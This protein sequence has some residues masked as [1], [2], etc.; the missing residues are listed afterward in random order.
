MKRSDTEI[1][2][3]ESID[4]CNLSFETRSK[5]PRLST[6]F[7]KCLKCQ[8]NL[9]EKLSKALHSSILKF[10]DAGKIRKDDVYERIKLE[11]NIILD[12]EQ[13][14]YWHTSCYKEYTNKTNLD[15]ILQKRGHAKDD[16][17]QTDVSFESISDQQKPAKIMRSSVAPL[18]WDLCIFCQNITKLK[19]KSLCQVET[20]KHGE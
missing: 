10:Y 1:D 18:N 2:D 6:D 13:C 19:S 11:E 15:R 4:D 16:I 3:E 12:P 5:S 7:L 17:K 20:M 9:K 14:F 8:C